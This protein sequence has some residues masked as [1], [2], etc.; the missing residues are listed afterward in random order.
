MEV[1]FNAI[2]CKRSYDIIPDLIKKRTTLK[3]PEIIL[4]IDII[5]FFLKKKFIREEKLFIKHFGVFYMKKFKKGKV[6]RFKNSVV[7]RHVVNGNRTF[8]FDPSKY[9]DT[10]DLNPI[11]KNI[12]RFFKVKP[13]DISFIFG[14]F[15]TGVFQV[16]VDKDL[17]K[18]RNFGIFYNKTRNYKNNYDSSIVKNVNNVVLVKFR[19]TPRFLRELNGKEKEIHCFKRCDNLLKLNGVDNKI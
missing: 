8:E 9:S 19:P 15:I 18:I 7:M 13:R 1:R 11:F 4:I 3:Y 17:I 14:L 12:A 6:I 16:L 5:L 10:Q 2:K